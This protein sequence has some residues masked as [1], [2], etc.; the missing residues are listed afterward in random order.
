MD[1]VFTNGRVSGKWK[2]CVFGINCFRYVEGER[3][4]KK[5]WNELWVDLADNKLLYKLGVA[6][7]PAAIRLVGLTAAVGVDRYRGGEGRG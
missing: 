1:A 7:L 2:G 6:K 3:E 4:R 5:E